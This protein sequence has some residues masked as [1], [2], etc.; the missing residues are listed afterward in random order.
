MPWK[1]FFTKRL[2]WRRILD[3]CSPLIDNSL[4]PSKEYCIVAF[5][6]ARGIANI[7]NSDACSNSYKW[8]YAMHC[9]V[10]RTVRKYMYLNIA[11]LVR[12][13]I[14]SHVVLPC[15]Q[16]FPCSFWRREQNCM[17]LRPL[18]S[19]MCQSFIMCILVHIQCC[20]I[21]ILSLSLCQYFQLLIWKALPL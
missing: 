21:N 16:G 17:M 12:G 20:K 6:I 7:V 15:P 9:V 4:G 2:S 5:D 18:S 19:P 1:I 13:W 3:I 14:W 8:D 10:S 11:I